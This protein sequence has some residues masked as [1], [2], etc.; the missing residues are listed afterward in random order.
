MRWTGD[1]SVLCAHGQVP[2]FAWPYWVLPFQDGHHSCVNLHYGKNIRQQVA[3]SHEGMTMTCSSLPQTHT[4]ACTHTRTHSRTHAHTHAFTHAR[5]CLHIHLYAREHV[6]TNKN[7]RLCTK[8]LCAMHAHH[9]QWRRPYTCLLTYSPPSPPS[10]A[11]MTHRSWVFGSRGS[12]SPG[13][14]S[15]RGSPSPPPLSR[16]SAPPPSA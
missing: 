1:A 7:T 2:E 6:R 10:T 14:G 13:T 3:R 8:T 4:H 5:T 16:V 15:W 11:H 9:A 12:C